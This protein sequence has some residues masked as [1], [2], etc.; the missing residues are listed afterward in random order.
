MH[1]L[2]GRVFFVCFSTVFK[3]SNQYPFCGIIL[4]CNFINNFAKLSYSLGKMHS[5]L[6]NRKYLM[7]FFCAISHN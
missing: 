3:H 7:V 6:F 1:K 2:K 4:S 5:I